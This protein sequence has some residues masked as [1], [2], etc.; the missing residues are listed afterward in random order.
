MLA[1]QRPPE[2]LRAESAPVAKSSRTPAAALRLSATSAQAVDPEAAW[3]QY[4][5]GDSSMLASIAPGLAVLTPGAGNEDWQALQ[6]THGAAGGGSA[7]HCIWAQG[8]RD[9]DGAS[10]RDARCVQ[11]KLAVGHLEGDLG[12]SIAAP[13]PLLPPADTAA[14]EP[15]GRPHWSA[16]QLQN[17]NTSRTEWQALY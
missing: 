6:H 5:A 2:R 3:A 13:A 15:T 9:G 16:G 1:H 4:A 14:T 8:A 17:Q 12:V 7:G 10:A 11:G